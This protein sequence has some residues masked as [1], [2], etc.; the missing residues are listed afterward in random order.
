MAYLYG[1]YQLWEQAV[2]MCAM[3]DIIS[4]EINS[5]YPTEVVQEGVKNL[6]L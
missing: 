4:P 5:M 3:G 6:P 1:L 2:C